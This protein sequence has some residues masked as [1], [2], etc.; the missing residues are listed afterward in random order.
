MI[1]DALNLRPDCPFPTLIIATL[2]FSSNPLYLMMP[3]MA[4]H[5][6][7][8]IRSSVRRKLV[9]HHAFAARQK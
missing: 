8:S 3:I 9:I 2:K 5:L 7:P 6:T 1:S 4:S